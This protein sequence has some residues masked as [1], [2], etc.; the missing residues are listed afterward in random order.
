M[1]C[2][3]FICVSISLYTYIYTTKTG[4]TNFISPSHSCL[5]CLQRMSGVV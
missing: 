2:K 4:V 1:T 5:L 3:V